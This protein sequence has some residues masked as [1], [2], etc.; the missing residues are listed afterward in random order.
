MAVTA[1]TETGSPKS[2]TILGSTGS[3]GCS[4]IDLIERNPDDY[5]VEALTAWRNAELLVEQALKLRPQF[6]AIGDED[7]YKAVKDALA[8]TAIEVGAG[9][10]AIVEA[11]KR[12]SELVISA[13]VGAAGLAPTMAAVGRG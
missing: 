9:A 4:T 10:A 2:V 5:V 7:C 11:A 3:V 12:P 8:G 13:I 6:V 1:Q